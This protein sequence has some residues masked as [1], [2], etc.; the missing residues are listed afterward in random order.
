MFEIVHNYEIHFNG[1]CE[2]VFDI[3][4]SIVKLMQLSGL[5]SSTFGTP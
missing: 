3:L 1:Y 5:T 4:G 2:L